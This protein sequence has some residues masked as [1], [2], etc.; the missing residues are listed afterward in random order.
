MRSLMHCIARYLLALFAGLLV[1]PH[2]AIAAYPPPEPPVSA[3]R[4]KQPDGTELIIGGLTLGIF[5]DTSVFAVWKRNADG[6]PDASF[7][8]DGL[9]TVAIWGT[10]DRPESLLV[11]PDG[12][13]VVAGYA[14]DPLCGYSCEFRVAIVRFNADGTLDRSFN[15][16]GRMAIVTM[17]ISARWSDFVPGGEIGYSVDRMMLTQDGTLLLPPGMYDDTF[18]RLHPDGTLDDTV[19]NSWG[20]FAIRQ[21]PLIQAQGLWSATPPESEPGWGVSF[22][23]ERETIFGTVYTYDLGGRPWWLGMSLQRAGEGVYRGSLYQRLGP[24]ITGST[25]DPSQLVQINMGEVT[26]TFADRDHAILDYDV[27]GTRQTKRI[28]RQAFGPSPLCTFAAQRDLDR[29]TNYQDLWGALPTARES[30]WSLNLAHQGELIFATWH[31]YDV[32]RQALWL[33]GTAYP[34]GAGG[35]EGTLTRVS[36][37]SYRSESWNA[38]AL[39]ATDVGSFR[40]AFTD[41]NSGVFSY[42]LTLGSPAVTVERSTPITRLVFQEPGTVCR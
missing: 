38:A 15:G 6:T 5:S 21:T 40:I 27:N 33:A 28:E 31:A 32:D 29:A 13:I 22:A 36:G 11:Q 16:D 41:G 42:R 1:A 18:I 7:N 39:A 17:I 20:K 30:G 2:A 26:L 10:D 4:F 8:G 37:P 34:T 3:Q 14:W 25:F 12:K 19:S 24:P 35:Y 23:H 9:A